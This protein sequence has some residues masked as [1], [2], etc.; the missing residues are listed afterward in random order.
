MGVDYV[1]YTALQKRGLL[2]KEYFE[3]QKEM[4]LVDL[5]KNS[6]P[7]I[8]DTNSTL[9]SNTN[10]L[11]FFDNVGSNSSS[12]PVTSF[13]DNPIQG[14]SNPISPPEGLGGSGSDD[15]SALKIKIDDFEYKFSRLIDRLEKIETRL[16]E[17][18]RNT[19]V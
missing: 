19:R 16:V 18:E 15:L 14:P 8:S 1:D 10:P 11:S 2:K 3:D 17:F 6:M 5:T 4:E 7:S 9:T 12:S 13:F